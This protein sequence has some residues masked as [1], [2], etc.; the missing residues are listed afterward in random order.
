MLIVE[1]KHKQ[2]FFSS[3]L[4]MMILPKVGINV[5]LEKETLTGER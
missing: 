3:S 1:E 4:R 5:G 2:I